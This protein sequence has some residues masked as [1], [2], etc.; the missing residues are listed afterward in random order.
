MRAAIVLMAVLAGCASTR[1]P[2]APPVIVSPA[3]WQQVDQQIFAASQTVMGPVKRYASQ[4]IDSWMDQVYQRTESEFIPWFTGYWTQQWLTLKVSWYKVSGG[5]NA[6]SPAQRLDAYLQ[7]EYHDQVLEPVSKSIDPDAVMAQTTRYY[8]QLLGEQ[9]Q[10]IA[11]R[12]NVPTDQF[13]QRLKD[14]PAISLTPSGPAHAS[15]YQVI[16]AKPL[17]ELP[18]FVALIDRVHKAAGGSVATDPGISSIA[19]HSSE[20]LEASLAPRGIA[21]AVA[22]AVGRVAGLAISVGMAGFGAITHQNER[23]DMEEQLR[24]SLYAALYEKKRSLID[25]QQTG[26]LAGAYYLSSQIEGRLGDAQ[27]FTPPDASG[28]DTF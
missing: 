10:G 15:L 25:D 4:S 23:A 9:I 16:H 6:Q 24:Q 18:A 19:I 8:I 13:D 1:P 20:K 7:D 14:I 11:Q 5:K 28:L 12:F 17:D 27:V 26:V 22:A 3:T 2:P 21:S